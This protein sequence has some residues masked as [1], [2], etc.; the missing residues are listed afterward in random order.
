MADRIIIKSDKGKLIG[1]ID[2]RKSVSA[3]NAAKHLRSAELP[4]LCN[5][6]N[7]N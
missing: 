2:K 6:Q 4:A 1:N 7:T 5:D 3:F